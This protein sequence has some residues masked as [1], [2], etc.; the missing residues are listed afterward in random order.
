MKI[1][2]AQTT[3]LKGNV[4]KN[5]Q[6][7]LRIIKRAI[8]LQADLIVFPELSITSYEPELAKDLVTDVNSSLFNPFQVLS[9]AHE[10]TIGIGMPTPAFDGIHIS[11]LIFQPKKD[12]LVYSK[13]I[14]HSDELPFFV[15]GTKQT[16][17]NIKGNKIAL[18]ICYETMQRE[19]FEHAKQL[20]AD[21]YI[22]SAA[23]AKG[24]M[25]TANS[26]YPKMAKEWDTPILLSN[27]IGFC[28]N[29][30]SVG[31]S[32]IWNQ[33]G[34]LLEQLDDQNEGLLIYDT[35]SETTEKHSLK[36]E[37]A[38]ISDLEDLFQI[39]LN[40]KNELEK[41]G[42]YQWTD[43]YPTISIIEND[44]RKG[45]LFTLKN[46]SKLI[47]AITIN[48][49]QEKEYQII[50]WKYDDTKVLVIHRLVVDPKH[51][52]QG[53]AH[54]MMDFA[55]DFAI[56]NDYTSIRLDAYSQHEKVIEFY[57]KRNY[58]VRGN[59]YFPGREFPF[60]CIEKGFQ[61]F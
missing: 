2:L 39:Y 16:I 51:Q 25:E 46:E 24:G 1:G 11:M 54:K 19:H 9:D 42:I 34:E 45:E 31:Q 52:K 41:N 21:I 8:K 61:K 10:I 29:F 13:Q 17:L 7:H 4:P 23:K 60:Y 32:A 40:G 3:S 5:I 57:K 44:I 18:G 53:Y 26:Y 20:G 12:R 15:C 50:P 14:L 55:E 33:N 43:S 6:D 58:V 59:V 47:G 36:I 37:K 38:Y 28:D 49:D 22:A 35:E 48:E 56:Q 27:A 30:I